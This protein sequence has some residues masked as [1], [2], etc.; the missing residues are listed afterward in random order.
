MCTHFPC[1]RPQPPCSRQQDAGFSFLRPTPAR[2]FMLPY[3]PA[4]PNTKIV[5]G[6]GGGGGKEIPFPPGIW[7]G[8]R[9]P[10]ERSVCRSG[11]GG[12][13]ALWDRRALQ[14]LQLF[15]GGQGACS[16]GCAEGP[17]ALPDPL[18]FQLQATERSEHPRSAWHANEFPYPVKEQLLIRHLLIIISLI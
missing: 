9:T 12:G 8:N 13:G 2:A 4:S 1:S 3:D 5:A 10:G 7:E 16:R 11:D 18:L 15:W 17:S 14:W 6:A